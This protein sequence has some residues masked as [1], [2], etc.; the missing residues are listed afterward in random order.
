MRK[1]RVGA[2]LGRGGAWLKF[3]RHSKGNSPFLIWIAAVA[4]GARYARGVDHSRKLRT[5]NIF[6][7]YSFGILGNTREYLGIPENTKEYQGILKNTK[8]Y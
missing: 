4:R 8:E 1:V 6:H 5:R 3:G 2:V 7:V